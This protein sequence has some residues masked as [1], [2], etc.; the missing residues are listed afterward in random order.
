MREDSPISHPI[1]YLDVF[2]ERPLAG[3]G[4]AVVDRADGVSDE[5]MLAFARETRL[6]ETTFLQSATVAEA[7]YRNRIWTPGEELRFAGHPSLGSA[8]ALAR[9]RGEA[10]A[11]YVQETGAGLQPIEVRREAGDDGERWHASMLQAEAAFGAELDP[12]EALA[13]VGLDPADADPALPPQIVST[14]IAHALVP[15]ASESALGRARP[16][17]VAI[18]A[19]LRPHDAV[20]LYLVRCEPGEGRARARGFARI[21]ALGEDPATGSAVG[22]LCAYLAGRAGTERIEVRQGEEIGRPSLLQAEMDGGGVRVSGYVVPLIAGEV[23]L[24]A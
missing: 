21:L 10:E 12:A 2:A 7:D 16:D 24:P 14:G 11:G 23:E 19:F 15:V 9:W 6:S 17:Y 18:D 22:P 20:V 1:S 4:L 8:V 3:N 13:V 5:V